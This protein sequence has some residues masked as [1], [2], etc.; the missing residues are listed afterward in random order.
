[1]AAGQEASRLMCRPG[2]RPGAA[3]P[4]ECVCG[5][6]SLQACWAHELGGILW[7][8]TGEIPQPARNSLHQTGFK[9][10]MKT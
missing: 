10:E 4:A 1:M 3:P 9:G 6:P 2:N 8:L 7:E 5:I